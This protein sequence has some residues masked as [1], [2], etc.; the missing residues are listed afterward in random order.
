MRIVLLS[1]ILLVVAGF[2]GGSTTFAHGGPGGP[3]PGGG[4]GG[5]SIPIRAIDGA[6]NNQLNPAWGAA[7]EPL[8]RVVAADYADG[9][10][11]P[12]G[13][14]RPSARAIS[15]SVAAQTESIP[16]AAGVSDYLWQWGQFLDHDLDLT[17]LADPTEPF[18]IP[19]PAGDPF[20]DPTGLGTISILLDRAHYEVIAGVREQTND[21][22]SYIDASN[23]YGSDTARA[24]ELR[25]LDGT[26]KLKVSAGDLLPFNLNGFP[27]AGGTDSSLFLAGDVRANEQ[28]GLTAMHTLFVREHNYWCDQVAQFDP[29][30]SGDQIYE[31]AR[32]IVGAEMQVITYQEF[33]PLLLG[34]NAIAPYTGYDPTVDAS[35]SNLFS[36]ASYRFGHTML[37]PTLLRL[38]ASL[39]EISA[40][41]LPLASA[42][43]NTGATINEGIEPLLRG[44]AHQAAQEIDPYLV[45]DVRNFLFGAPGAGGFDLAS[46]NIQRGRDHGLPSYNQVRSELGLTPA[47]SFADVSSDPEI[48]SRLAA[49]YASVND[50]DPW[51]GGLAEDHAPQALVG[52]LVGTVLAMQFKALRDGDRYWYELTLPGTLRNLVEQQTLADIIR[53]NTTI[54]S[55]IPDN[56]FLVPGTG[57]FVRGDCNGSGGVDVAD[58]IQLLSFLFRSAGPLSCDDACDVNNDGSLDVGDAIFSLTFLFGN[59]PAPASPFPFCGDDSDLDSLDCADFSPCS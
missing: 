20:F 34:P 53:R 9:V 29:Q 55:E 32:A 54:G 1:P 21:I 15:N 22:T 23:V 26:G 8:L 11:A 16:N 10:S 14:N 3:G 25:A 51:V 28:A 57:G 4:P 6:D 59:G 46:L 42:F 58:S 24:N 35:I 5:N 56:V 38:D 12:S 44:L 13:A 36:T 40:G 33:L 18:D 37:S 17:E 2:H 52:E 39:T 27:N 41:H 7:G 19:V 43:F 47:A 31:R 45:D 50:I 48:Q 30:L 49:A